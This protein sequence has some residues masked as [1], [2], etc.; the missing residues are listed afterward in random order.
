MRRYEV[1]LI[2]TGVDT[3][4]EQAT[5]EALESMA[6]QI[7]E[8]YVR[9][10]RGHDPRQPPLGRIVSARVDP[11]GDGHFAL[12]GEMEVWDEADE[13]EGIK[14]DGRSLVPEPAPRNT[15]DVLYDMPSAAELGLPFLRELA[16][17]A[18]PTAK[19]RYVAKKAIE[20]LSALVIV[21]G[22]VGAIATG[23]LKKLGEDL[24]QQVKSKLK[25]AAKPQ[26]ERERLL[27]IRMSLARPGRG[28]VAVEVVLTNPT[29]SDVDS[30]L[31]S[32]LAAVEALVIRTLAENPAAAE[33]VIEVV[34]R[35]PRLLYSLRSD[36]V[37]S[38]IKPVAHGELMTQGLSLGATVE[39]AEERE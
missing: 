35:Q 14:G 26:P 23:F 36:G 8:R 19:P 10:G 6:R 4:G 38:V 24:Y 15:F 20:P 22:I 17:L 37:P 5:K 13:P 30:L 12:N 27:A 33:V 25:V 18:G 11:I 28:P 1:T 9:V 29:G 32:G 7:N 31:T 39:D 34:D 2:T 16:A 3:Q 21:I